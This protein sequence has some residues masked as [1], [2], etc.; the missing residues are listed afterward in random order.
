[1]LG[2]DSMTLSLLLVDK[3]VL[4]KVLKF[5]PHAEKLKQLCANSVQGWVPNNGSNTP[6][7]KQSVCT[8]VVLH[9]LHIR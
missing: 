5:L 9:V 4:F 2:D 6:L 1:M 3:F 7:T 8:M